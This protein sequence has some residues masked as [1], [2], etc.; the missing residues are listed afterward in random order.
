MNKEE[1]ISKLIK[2]WRIRERKLADS[3]RELKR[4]D[5]DPEQPLV[6]AIEATSAAIGQCADELETGDLSRIEGI[7][8]RLI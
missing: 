2:L 5:V 7:L 6:Q 3:A 8:A 1:M 4:L